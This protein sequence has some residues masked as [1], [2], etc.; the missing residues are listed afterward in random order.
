MILQF[1]TKPVKNL[2]NWCFVFA[3]LLH[4][5]AC[6]KEDGAPK[7]FVNGL[8][9]VSVGGQL[10]GSA[11]DSLSITLIVPDSANKNNLK[12]YF[13]LAPG[14][15]AFIDNNKVV[16]G[17]VVDGTEPLLLAVM[18]ND[19]KSS[20]T[21]KVTIQTK[22]EYFG[23]SGSLTNE[24]SLNRDYNFYFDQFDGS[25][26]Q[27]ID[28]CPT[29]CTMAIKWADSTFT[30][31]PLQARDAIYEN[32]LEW[33]AQDVVSYLNQNKISNATV[34]AS[35][36]DSLVKVSIDNG[37]LLIVLPDMYYYIGYNNIAY[38]HTQKFYQT[39][40]ANWE[41]CLLVKGYKQFSTGL[42]LEIYDPYSDHNVYLDSI[43]EQLEGSQLKGKN[44]YYS[45]DDIQKSID[46]ADLPIAI[47]VAPKGQKI[48]NAFNP[49]KSH[50]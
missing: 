22:M 21:Y 45:C 44:R 50:T 17:S 46:F 24:K 26:L 35:N 25:P 18:S 49:A 14:A 1:K 30:G 19:K 9:S 38:Q 40:T 28:C 48:T 4:V 41:H 34:S 15:Q 23:I 3:F 5:F 10:A 2:I 7:P 13:T 16:S 33:P 20:S 29:V 37:Q 27:S 31:T 43:N 42:W 12:I 8:L 39:L 47:I 36:L 6:K 11:I 32:G